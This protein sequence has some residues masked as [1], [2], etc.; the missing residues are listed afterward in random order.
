MRLK[1]PPAMFFF[2][3]VL[4]FVCSFMSPFVSSLVVVLGDG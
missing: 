1:L 2:C 4:F 3:G